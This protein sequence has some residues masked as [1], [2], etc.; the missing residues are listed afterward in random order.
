MLES[1]TI[2]INEMKFV[3]NPLKGFKAL[4]LDKKLISLVL[5][6]LNGVEDMDKEIDLGKAL[7]GLSGAL[8]G[9]PESEYEIFVGDLISTVQFLP[10]DKP[11]VEMTIKIIDE[12]FQG[13]MMTI[14]QLMFKVMEYNKFTPFVLVSNGGKGT[15]KTLISKSLT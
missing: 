3:L 13:E 4:K 2:D 15:I 9:L 1:K 6:L 7:G 8:D 14:Y 10:A 11:P 5:P 12:Y